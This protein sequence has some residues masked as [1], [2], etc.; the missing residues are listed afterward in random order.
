MCRKS[1]SMQSM[2]TIL[3]SQVD[4]KGKHFIMLRLI[5]KFNLMVLT[6]IKLTVFPAKAGIHL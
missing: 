6:A 5:I 2:L 3:K 1:L 4:N